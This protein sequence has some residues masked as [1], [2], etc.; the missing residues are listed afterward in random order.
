MKK[1]L[2]QSSTSI[3]TTK[4]WIRPAAV[5]AARYVPAITNEARRLGT[6]PLPLS[7]DS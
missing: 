2:S 7:G 5:L 6:Y 1:F 4:N 3:A